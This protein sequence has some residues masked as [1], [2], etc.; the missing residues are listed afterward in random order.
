M[1]GHYISDLI[2]KMI[3]FLATLRRIQQACQLEIFNGNKRLPTRS[4]FSVRTIY[5]SMLQTMR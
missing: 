5:K 1:T 4:G 3:K 2:L